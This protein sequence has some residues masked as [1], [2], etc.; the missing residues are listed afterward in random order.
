MTMMGTWIC[1]GCNLNYDQF[2][3]E[4]MVIYRN[5]TQNQNSWTKIKLH[6]IQANPNGY[7][8]AVYLYAGDTVLM[9]Y[10]ESGSS[11]LS[12]HE[13]ILT[14]GLGSAKK[15]DS[16][17]VIWP[18]GKVQM[19]YEIP[20]SQLNHIYEISDEEAFFDIIEI[21]LDCYMTIIDPDTIPKILSLWT[22]FQ[23]ITT[24]TLNMNTLSAFPNWIKMWK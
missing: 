11:Y 13:Q 17:R 2:T 19:H 15:V 22:Q 12:S 8:S 10:T 9:R 1:F 23:I 21:D 5:D 14:I 18:G 7:N 6:G 20:L 24:L 16:L 4:K 3:N